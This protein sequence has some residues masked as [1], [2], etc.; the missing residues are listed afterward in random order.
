MRTL[1]LQKVFSACLYRIG[2]LY[3][4]MMLQHVLHYRLPIHLV[5]QVRRFDA[6]AGISF[7]ATFAKLDMTHQSRGVCKL[8]STADAL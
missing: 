8:L 5:E 1:D 2:F 3:L 7:V 6:C 4:T